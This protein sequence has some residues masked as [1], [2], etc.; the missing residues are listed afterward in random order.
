MYLLS[1]FLATP[2]GN[3]VGSHPYYTA[4][5]S[6]NDVCRSC[7]VA[8]CLCGRCRA[9]SRA[10]ALLLLSAQQAPDGSAVCC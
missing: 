1:P 10:C 8:K 2:H 3:D 4:V 5:D 9:L 6:V 7:V